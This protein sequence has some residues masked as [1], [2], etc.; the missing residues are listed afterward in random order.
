MPEGT[1]AVVE[2]EKVSRW[3]GPVIGLNDVTLTFRRGVTGLLGPNGAGKSTMLKMITG[4][5]H[6]SQGSVR[7]FG[8]SVFANPRVMAR[9][10]VSPEHDHLFEAWTGRAHVEYLLRLGGFSAGEA[11]DLAEESLQKVGLRQVEN[12]KVGGYSKGMRQRLRLSI[13]TAHDPELIVLDEPLNGLDPV[14]RNEVMEYIR[15]LADRG[16]TI[17]VSGHVLY[18]VEKMTRRIVLIHKGRVLAEGTLAEIRQALDQRPHRVRIGTP[19]PREVARRVL[20]VDGVV[21]VHI[22]DRFAEIQTQDPGQFF[23][24]LMDVAALGEVPV[25]NYET[26]DDN[27]QAI[28]DYLIR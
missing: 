6:A 3:Y 19:N 23:A 17:I 20:E 28:F 27:L 8:E 26:T 9:L 16:R 10:G 15:E 7:V 22:G 21:S 13:A 24:R 25:E 11:R 14:G 1:E 18:E 12:R 2:L 5:I 4:Q